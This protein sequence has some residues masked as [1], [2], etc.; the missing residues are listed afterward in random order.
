MRIERC[1]F[2]VHRSLELRKGAHSGRSAQ[3]VRVGEGMS[4]RLFQIR[5]SRR[6]LLKLF[7]ASVAAASMPSLGCV[8][9]ESTAAAGQADTSIT[10]EFFTPAER[11]V[12]GA[13]ADEVLPP[14]DE[15]GGARLGAVIF[16]ER[17]LTSLDGPTP[18]LWAGGP[19]SG[20]TTFPDGQRPENDFAQFLPLDRVSL[21]AW[22]L[23]LY[24][25]DAVGGG[26]NDAVL[27]K[28]PG[29]RNDFKRNLG[30]LKPSPS[31]DDFEPD[32]QVTF[33]DLVT[34]AAFGAPEYGGNPNLSGW[35]AVY[36]DG[37]SAPQGFSQLDPAT[38]TFVERP[39]QPLSTANPGEDPERMSFV[40]EMAIGTATSLF[41]GK[42][43]P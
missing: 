30:L 3:C 41:N 25:S 21:L 10:I 34:Q 16:I 37:D 8:S 42:V 28:T 7:G 17:F 26:P 5:A 33:I 13:L 18:Q 19:F 6:G 39:A 2:A 24:G 20:R 11:R 4:D 1:A 38:N 12:L 32:F 14:D 35:K 29:L 23:A 36:F 15:P 43:F 9:K 40:L 27:G 31:L 22:K